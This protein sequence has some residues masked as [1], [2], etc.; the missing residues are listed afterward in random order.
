MS[1]LPLKASLDCLK[2]LDSG[3]PS[4]VCAGFIVQAPRLHLAVE[5]VGSVTSHF[6]YI[7]R[8][9]VLR[10]RQREPILPTHLDFVI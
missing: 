10:L 1:H 2:E 8:T 7:R 3:F 4:V 6:K 5:Y 9:A